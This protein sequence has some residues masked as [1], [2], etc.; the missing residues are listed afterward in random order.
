MGGGETDL[1]RTLDNLRQITDNL[2][3][4]TENAKQLPVA[5]DPRRAAPPVKGSQP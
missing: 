5:T 1:K 2:R 4:I 3:E